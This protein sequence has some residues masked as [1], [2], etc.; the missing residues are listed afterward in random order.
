MGKQ[1]SE[2]M[3]PRHI[4]STGPLLPF[5]NGLSVALMLLFSSTLPLNL[6]WL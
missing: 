4:S 2:R 5:P 1:I 6:I 3:S